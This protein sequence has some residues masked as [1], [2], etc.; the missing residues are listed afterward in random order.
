MD[1]MVIANWAKR[2][3]ASMPTLLRQ[4]TNA[5]G[6]LTALVLLLPAYGPPPT[7]SPRTQE[8]S[9]N[10]WEVECCLVCLVLRALSCVGAA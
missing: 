2:N 1:W 7:I 6:R 5:Q 10:Y 9:G 8:P 4:R 3:T